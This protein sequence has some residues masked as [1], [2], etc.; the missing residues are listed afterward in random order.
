M[1]CLIVRSCN[2]EH[3][4]PS[5]DFCSMYGKDL[6][7]DCLISQLGML[8]DLLQTVNDQQ[9]YEIKRVTSIGTVVDIMNVNNFSKTFLSEV[10]CLIRM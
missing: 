7:I 4:K 10:D 5:E 2:G 1:E 9:H 6:Q 3:V 8:P